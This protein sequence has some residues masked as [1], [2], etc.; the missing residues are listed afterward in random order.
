MPRGPFL[1]LFRPTRSSAFGLVELLVVILVLAVL[2]GTLVPRVSDR[3]AVAR[4][5][6]RLSDIRVLREAIE[7]YYLDRGAY[8]PS[9]SE[10]QADGWD[11]SSDG[12]F[13]PELFKTG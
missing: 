8:P 12:S 4:D 5:S 9:A 11:S 3:R 1:R 6:Q 7:Q 13:I 2:A 10:A